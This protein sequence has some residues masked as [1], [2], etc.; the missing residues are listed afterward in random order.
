MLSAALAPSPGSKFPKTCAWLHDDLKGG[1]TRRLQESSERSHSC[2]WWG[3]GSSLSADRRIQSG[4]EFQ[5][6]QGSWSLSGRPTLRGRPGYAWEPLEPL[7]ALGARV[8]YTKSSGADF[9][10]SGLIQSRILVWHGF[11]DSFIGTDSG[12]FFLQRGVWK[13]KDIGG[14]NSSFRLDDKQEPANSTCKIGTI[15]RL[16]TFGNRQRVSSNRRDFSKAQPHA[17]RT[18]RLE[19]PAT[20]RIINEKDTLHTK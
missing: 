15:D 10:R 19:A 7:E 4:G 1:R 6:G 5:H 17:C 14:A 20:T 8:F 11:G 2:S 9:F 3:V 18:A 13:G 16:A 12:V